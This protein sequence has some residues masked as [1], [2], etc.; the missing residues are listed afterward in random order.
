MF[1]HK[2]ADIMTRDVIT[3]RK[4][5]SVE[6]A[7]RLMARYHVSGLPV[8]DVDMRLVG[9]LSEQDVLLRGQSASTSALLGYIGSPDRE[10]ESV[11]E[12]QRKA[13]ASL[14][15]D[16]MTTRVVAY[17]EDSSVADIA[18]RMIELN[19]NRVPILRNGR[20]AGIISRSDIIKSMA[21]LEFDEAPDRGPLA[22]R[23]LDL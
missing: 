18:R 15:E 16:A 9:I 3:V 2:A 6:E 17:E 19:I 12:A 1:P 10:D 8:V 21:S 5:S 23:R 22:D 11:I 14:V 7:L 13:M 20:V 4:G